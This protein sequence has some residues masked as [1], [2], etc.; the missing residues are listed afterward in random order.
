MSRVEDSHVA[1]KAIKQF[2]RL[3]GIWSS[4][5][6]RAGVQKPALLPERHT[7]VACQRRN[8]PVTRRSFHQLV[9]GAAVPRV[10]SHW[11]WRGPFPGSL[12]PLDRRS[13]SGGNGVRRHSDGS[14]RL[15]R[16]PVGRSRN[17]C[18]SSPRWGASRCSLP[19]G[20]ILPSLFLLPPPWGVLLLPFPV[21]PSRSGVLCL[22]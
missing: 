14:A 11:L 6:L 8:P 17:R 1:S 4:T 20:I 19:G 9:E 3:C 5:P 2:G 7:A 12:P 15:R 16:R 21:T 22:R 10:N 18:C 13:G